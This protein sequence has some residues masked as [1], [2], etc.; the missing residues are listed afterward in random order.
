MEINAT[1]LKAKRLKLLDKIAHTREPIIITKHGKPVAK[2]VPIAEEA[3]QLHTGFGC[4]AG[5]IKI[6]GDIV[7][8]IEEPWSTVTGEEDELYQAPQVAEDA[9]AS[10]KRKP[11]R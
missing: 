9:N 3:E 11:A 6:T 2:V 1:E 4:M 10:R 5:T 7:A 8:P